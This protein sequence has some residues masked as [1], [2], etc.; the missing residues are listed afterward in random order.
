MNKEVSA[1]GL[2]RGPYDG[3]LATN[4]W[5]R[6]PPRSR[7]RADRYGS[8]A[9]A[10]GIAGGAR[11]SRSEVDA[12]AR[13]TEMTASTSTA[14]RH[15][16]AR[17]LRTSTFSAEKGLMARL[18]SEDRAVDMETAAIGAAAAAPVQLVG[19]PASATGPATTSSTRRSSGWRTR[20]QRTGP[21]SAS[22]RDA[23]MLPRLI[24]RARRAARG[25]RG[26]CALRELRG[27]WLLIGAPAARASPVAATGH[28]HRG[29]YQQIGSGPLTRAR[30]VRSPANSGTG[31]GGR[32]DSSGTE[33][34]FVATASSVG[35]TTK[36]QS[37]RRSTE[38][39]R[40]QSDR[41]S[42]F[43]PEVQFTW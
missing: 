7:S 12:V 11:A 23:L 17:K 37:I 20:R 10:I 33:A 39:R 15:H 5:H 4:R 42:S 41:S 21:R 19:V 40:L 43:L 3:V 22:P 28:V 30:R 36:T 27:A 2:Y 29:P 14:P 32:A 16:P 25:R 13:S 8:T 24:D 34:H 26:R 6:P 1:T 18:A 9:I 38:V 31:D 35:G